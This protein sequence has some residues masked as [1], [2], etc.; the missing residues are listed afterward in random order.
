MPRCD[1]F[2]RYVFGVGLQRD[3]GVACQ[4]DVLVEDVE[5][6]TPAVSPKLRRRSAADVET[7]EIEL[8]RAMAACELAIDGT[9]VFVDRHSR[10]H[11]D[12]KIAIDAATRTERNVNVQVLGLHPR[13]IASAPA[14]LSVETT[15]DRTSD[16]QLCDGR[17]T[18]RR[19][20]RAAMTQRID[21][22]AAVGERGPDASLVA[23]GIAT[24]HA[25]WRRQI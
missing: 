20:E 15:F 23:I 12:G 4:S 17:E 21:I 6:S 19:R 18:L 2:R 24:V 14:D 22:R 3:L 1:R 9:Q 16:L 10:P 25:R 11:G 7:R 5:K 13:N 8:R